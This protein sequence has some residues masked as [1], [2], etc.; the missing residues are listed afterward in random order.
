ME[1]S[2]RYLA[3]KL[4]ADKELAMRLDHALNGV[5]KEAIKKG[6]SLYD[7]F[8]RLTW[9]TSC[10]TQN[11]QD[12]CARLK[13]EDYRFL[14]GMSKL[15]TNWNVIET[16]VKPYVEF[17]LRG[18]T[19][20]GIYNIFVFLLKLGA[21]ITGGIFTSTA[22]IQSITQ[23]IVSAM[24]ISSAIVKDNLKRISTYTLWGLSAYSYVDLAARKANELK[25]FN[26]MYY[27]ALYRME[28][29]M[30]YFLIEPVI[31]RNNH[32]YPAMNSE[33]EIAKKLYRLM[34]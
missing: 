24:S 6:L 31:S 33:K 22:I 11:D 9:Y 26:P 25:Q 14:K 5:Q 34:H 27:R 17:F 1:T 19:E 18:H 3:A 8:E 15:V 28:L 13:H 12:V 30:M 2:N 4:E 16:M 20:K 29:E 7:A 32:I 10:L 21:N 23:A